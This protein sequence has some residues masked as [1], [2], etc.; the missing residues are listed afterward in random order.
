M[1]PFMKAS[2]SLTRPALD[3]VRFVAGRGSPLPDDVRRSAEELLGEDL[4][5]VRVHVMSAAARAGVVA[6]TSGSDIYF[7]PRRYD[8]RSPEGLHLLGHELTHVAQQ[9]RGRARNPHGYGVAVVRDLEL[10]AEADRMGRALQ[11][12]AAG[13]KVP[14]VPASMPRVRE[15]ARGAVQRSSA[16]PVEPLWYTVF[17]TNVKETR[18]SLAS[19]YLEAT[20]IGGAES[21]VA[22]TIYVVQD[23]EPY[24]GKEMACTSNIST[25]TALAMYA[26]KSGKCFLFHADAGSNANRLAAFIGAYIGYL[27]TTGE[28]LTDKEVTITL[29][30]TNSTAVDSSASSVQPIIEAFMIALPDTY[31]Q[32]LQKARWHANAQLQYA[33]GRDSDVVVG[34][35]KAPFL[36]LLPGDRIR[37]LMERYAG[38]MLSATLLHDQLQGFAALGQYWRDN[39]ALLTRVAAQAKTRLTNAHAEESAMI[40]NREVY[41]DV[42]AIFRAYIDYDLEV[43]LD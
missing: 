4:S 29:F 23:A 36:A 28:A 33:V 13:P 12:A 19:L 17:K 7:A 5:D 11:R 21:F 3:D 20:K 34:G 32:V 10:E 31:T 1:L 43:T 35:G 9:R 25:C 16:E 26:G 30:F 27:K 2:A 8:P 39:D 40:A 6:F 15:R 18:E 37:Y 14:K 24:I 41:D 42:A 38:G 22:G